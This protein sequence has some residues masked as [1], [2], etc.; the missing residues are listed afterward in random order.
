MSW[1][2]TDHP[3]CGVYEIARYFGVSKGRVS[4]YAEASWFP[5]PSSTLKMGRVWKS[6]QVKSA[7]L[8]HKTQMERHRPPT[9]YAADTTPEETS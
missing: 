3:E 4:Q 1:D 8:K 2:I 5:K 9:G 6:A 7:W